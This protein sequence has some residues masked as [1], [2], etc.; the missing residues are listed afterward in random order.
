MPRKRHDIVWKNALK[1]A[2]VIG[3]GIAGCSTAYELAERGY[4]V[5]LLEREHALATAASGNPLAILYPRLTG[6]DTAL[7]QLNIQGY[8]HSLRLITKLGVDR[9]QYLACGVAQLLIQQRHERHIEALTSAFSSTSE[10]EAIFKIMDAAQLSDVAGVTISHEGLYFSKA[11]G[12][13]LAHLCK[14]LVDHPRI[15]V[16]PHHAALSIERN[17]TNTQLWQVSATHRPLLTADVIVIA[18]ANDA[19]QL[20]QSQHIPLTAVRG[21]ISYLTKTPESACLKTI[22]CGEGYITPPID[23]LHYLGA[24]FNRQDTDPS[25]RDT[26]HESNLDL[27]KPL[28]AALYQQLQ[29][30]VAS[31]RVAWRSQTP[32]YLPA[33]GQLLD[34]NALVTGKFYYNDTQDKLPWMQG[35]YVNIG[36]GSKGFLSAPLCAAIIADHATGQA[37]PFPL[38]LLNGLQP[39]RFILRKMGLKKLAQHLVG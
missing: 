15:R 25:A 27:L 17:E 5:T 24:S 18:N 33:A 11:G 13:N 26:D 16:L 4:E 1:S 38:T 14:V 36:H 10:S 20:K 7:E 23:Q 9:C 29:N 31:G 21:Q 19:H 30:R 6:Q 3:G 22:L 32:D 28:S 12:I 37:S 2:I 39:N 8:L 35:I 34:T